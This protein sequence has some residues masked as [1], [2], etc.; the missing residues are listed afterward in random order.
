MLYS[1]L[2]THASISL[3]LVANPRIRRLEAIRPWKK[4]EYMLATCP[5]LSPFSLPTDSVVPRQCQHHR[6][7]RYAGAVWRQIFSRLFPVSRAGR[8]GPRVTTRVGRR[9]GL[10][11]HGTRGDTA[12]IA[13][14]TGI[15]AARRAT[16]P[17]AP[18]RGVLAWQDRTTA[19]RLRGG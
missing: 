9:A 2:G 18:R 17:H 3:I 7:I 19:R 16:A 6:R 5:Y 11:R 1:R 15:G 13:S 8:P 12:P 4:N 10:R 14:S